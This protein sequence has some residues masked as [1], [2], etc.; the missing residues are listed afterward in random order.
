MDQVYRGYHYMASP[1]HP[2]WLIT[3]PQGIVVGQAM[4]EAA[5]QAMIDSLIGP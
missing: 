1:N 2:G 5:A 3:D 4:T